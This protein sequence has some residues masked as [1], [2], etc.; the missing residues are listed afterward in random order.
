MRSSS[1]RRVN[2]T[3]GFILIFLLG[4]WFPGASTWAQQLPAVQEAIHRRA[5]P[6]V[7]ADTK[8]AAMLLSEA[9]D[10]VQRDIATATR[11][12]KLSYYVLLMDLL[13]VQL[14]IKDREGYVKTA[15]EILVLLS[16]QA[17]DSSLVGG[18]GGNSTIN[19]IIRAFRIAGEAQLV[20]RLIDGQIKIIE[21]KKEWVEANNNELFIYKNPQIEDEEW[22]V[23][24]RTLNSTYHRCRVMEFLSGIG[25]DRAAVMIAKDIE[26]E[27]FADCSYQP[28]LRFLTPDLF[29]ALRAA[30]ENRERSSGLYDAQSEVSD[31]SLRVQLASRLAA[32]GRVTEA[33]RVA[34]TIR[35]R[36]ERERASLYIA[37]AHLQNGA[38][39][40]ARDHY[41]KSGEASSLETKKDFAEIVLPCLL[42]LR[43]DTP[44]AQRAYSQHVSKYVKN[45]TW[46]GCAPPNTTYL[47]NQPLRLALK[48][49]F[50]A[51]KAAAAD[52]A[53]RMGTTGDHGPSYW[54][55]NA[56]V[57][58]ATVVGGD[59]GFAKLAGIGLGD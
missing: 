47:W 8:Y 30:K 53:R 56:L 58:L 21:S 25:R 55:V 27:G 51:A 23:L 19:E 11:K 15:A 28:V 2:V 42:E 5:S 17:E 57:E 33:N 41:Y 9:F 35:S 32:Y 6:L 7:K 20:Q 49:N 24:S 37:A 34:A 3:F 31:D 43:G 59:L 16:Q 54:F 13:K 40:E 48:G 18:M 4:G 38:L 29:E 45:P 36:K 46:P 22:L 12:Q 39:E 10:F 50:I 1:V 52:S 14:F 44:A 26:G